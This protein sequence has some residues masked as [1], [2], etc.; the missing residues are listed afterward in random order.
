MRLSREI[1]GGGRADILALGAVLALQS[2][3]TRAVNGIIGRAQGVSG[4]GD[5]FGGANGSTEGT[6]STLGRINQQR[7]GEN[8]GLVAGAILSRGLQR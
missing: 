7:L 3:T 2:Q 8:V 5:T 4:G 6:G 1:N